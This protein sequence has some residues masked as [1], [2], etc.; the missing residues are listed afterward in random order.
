MW[1][2]PRAAPGVHET[3]EVAALAGARVR[4]MEEPN[5]RAQKR[6][7]IS[8]TE[9]PSTHYTIYTAILQAPQDRSQHDAQR[10]LACLLT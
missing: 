7:E 8:A 4:R 5:V 10:D 9:F 1:R 3:R 6:P 2:S